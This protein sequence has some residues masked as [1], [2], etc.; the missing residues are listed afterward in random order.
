MAAYNEY[1]KA[2]YQA[3][4]GTPDNKGKQKPKRWGLFAGTHLVLE[5]AYPL[6]KWKMQNNTE[7]YQNLKIK[8]IK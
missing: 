2:H 1:Q 8:P 5:G 3:L 7:G 4:Y 6:L